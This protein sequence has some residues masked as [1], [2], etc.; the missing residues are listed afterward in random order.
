MLEKNRETYP[1]E[2]DYDYKRV[3]EFYFSRN[4]C[5]DWVYLVSWKDFGQTHFKSL[6]SSYEAKAVVFCVSSSRTQNYD[7]QTKAIGR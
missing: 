7:Q 1:G 6:E 2:S 4:A 5:R 3:S